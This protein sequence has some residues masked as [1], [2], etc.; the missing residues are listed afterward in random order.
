MYIEGSSMQS[1]KIEKQSDAERSKI[2]ILQTSQ[3]FPL[4]ILF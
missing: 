2:E 4:Q 1:G 3:H